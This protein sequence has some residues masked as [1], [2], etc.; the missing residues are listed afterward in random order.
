MAAEEINQTGGIPPAAVGGNTRP[1]VV[2]SCDESTDLVRAAK[3]LALDLRVPAIVGPNT[4]QDT[5]DVS[6]K[7]TIPAGTL[8]MTPTAVASGIADLSDQ[9]LTWLMV[10]SDVQRAPLMIEQIGELETMLRTERATP[11]IKL[12]VIFRNDALGIGTR[13]SLNTMSLNGKSLTDSI[14]AG[15]AKST[16]TI[17]NK[18]TRAP[19]SRSTKT[20]RPTS[21]SSRAPPR[22]SPAS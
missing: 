15:N 1:L 2:V 21:S 8:V 3:H 13:T 9:G 10:P 6:N 5:L 19:W 12:G 7:V 14:S 17:S 20:S 22:Q 4:S 16:A 18:P 11:T